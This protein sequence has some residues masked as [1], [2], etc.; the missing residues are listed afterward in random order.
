MEKRSFKPLVQLVHSLLVGAA[1]A[2]FGARHP[3]KNASPRSIL[4]SNLVSIIWMWPMYGKGEAERVVGEAI[5]DKTGLLFASQQNADW[6]RQMMK[7]FTINSML[8]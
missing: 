1:S 4:P 6:V 3:E 7:R 8:R 2:T 5:K